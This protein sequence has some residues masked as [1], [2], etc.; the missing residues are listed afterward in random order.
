M[1]TVRGCFGEWHGRNLRSNFVRSIPANHVQDCLVAPR[2]I[3]QPRIR[4]DYPAVD[5]EYLVTAGN[6]AFNLSST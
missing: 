3:L 2:M 1:V 4:S 5:Y 6:Q